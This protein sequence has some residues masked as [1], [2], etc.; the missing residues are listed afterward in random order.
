MTAY[1]FR[2]VNEAEEPTGY[3]GFAFGKNKYD[4]FWQIDEH[5]DP[6]SV[7][8]RTIDRGSVCFLIENDELIKHEIEADYI[9]F[10]TWK[11]PNWDA[12]KFSK[13]EANA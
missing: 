5:G 4:L 13:T 3:Y 7:Q 2:F 12:L 11:R 6:Y 8:V 10:G 1:A 9:E